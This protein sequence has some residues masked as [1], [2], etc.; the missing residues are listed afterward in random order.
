[1]LV[2]G[3]SADCMEFILTARAHFFPSGRASQ[4]EFIDFVAFIHLCA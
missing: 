4:D 1:M 2:G 3:Y